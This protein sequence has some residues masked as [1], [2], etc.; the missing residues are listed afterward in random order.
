[1]LRLAACLCN[2]NRSHFWTPNRKKIHF[3]CSLHIILPNN[4]RSKS[5][6]DSGFC[7]IQ[8]ISPFQ[9][10][11]WSSQFPQGLHEH[12]TGS[13]GSS[14][15]EE[16]HQTTLVN[17]RKIHIGWRRERKRRKASITKSGKQVR[18]SQWRVRKVP[19]TL[20]WTGKNSICMENT[21]ITEQQNGFRWKGR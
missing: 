15:Q 4:F 17:M 18:W 8:Y 2:T 13:K 1:M 21:K 3:F 9:S 12:D 16:E 6:V 19:L 11:F 7:A 20:N 5:V 14:S 10:C